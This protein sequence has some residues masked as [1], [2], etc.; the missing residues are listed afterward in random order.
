VTTRVILDCDNACGL[1]GRDV[2]D[3]LALAFLL[4]REDVSLDGVTCTFGNAPLDAVVRC[5][6][7][8]LTRARRTDLRAIAGAKTRGHHDTP[9][10]AFLA[11]AA[12]A[13]PG[14]LVVIATGPLTNLAAA[15]RHDPGFFANVRAIHC[16]GGYFG[17]QRIGLRA[18][19]EL[20]LSADPDAAA[21]VF[22]SSA[23]VVLF[24]TEVCRQLPFRLRD[25][26]SLRGVDATLCRHLITWLACYGL[27]RATDRIF[28]W[29]VLPAL[30]VTHPHLFGSSVRGG[31]PDRE[32]LSRGR[33]VLRSRRGTVLAPQTLSGVAGLR[34]D[35]AAAWR[36]ALPAKPLFSR[37]RGNSLRPAGACGSPAQGGARDLV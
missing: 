33:V 27:S 6:D 21:V 22:E 37:I 32:A 2:D 17:M 7:R 11:Q 12:A 23:E 16:M 28:L 35:V 31:S 19:G 10:A 18:A 9:A 4:G 25:I 1:P 24:G 34:R 5:T 15:A 30:G 8:L 36:R 14:E 29:D 20:N 13:E 3:A 26:G